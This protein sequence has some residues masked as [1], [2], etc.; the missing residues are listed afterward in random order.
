MKF[1]ATLTWKSMDRSSLYDTSRSQSYSIVI[2]RFYRLWKPMTYDTRLLYCLV[3]EIPVQT[4]TG[5]KRGAT[6]SLCVN[7]VLA[8]LRS[9]STDSVQQSVDCVP[10]LCS[11]SGFPRRPALTSRRAM[12]WLLSVSDTHWTN[13]FTLL[14][15]HSVECLSQKYK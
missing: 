3:E 8:R 7:W 12:T 6:M 2:K 9:L 13:V 5:R 14:S 4:R 15:G 11:G 1:L 10:H